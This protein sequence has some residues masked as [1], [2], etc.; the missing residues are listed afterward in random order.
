MYE[1]PR[2]IKKGEYVPSNSEFTLHVVYLTGIYSTC[3]V[4]KGYIWGKFRIAN[5]SPYLLDLHI[6]FL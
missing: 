2:C 1:P 6:Y 3:S 5:M 4:L